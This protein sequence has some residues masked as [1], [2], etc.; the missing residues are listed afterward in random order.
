MHRAVVKPDVGG[1][2]DGSSLQTSWRLLAV[3]L[4]IFLPGMEVKVCI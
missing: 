2:G 1:G 3:G 4:Y